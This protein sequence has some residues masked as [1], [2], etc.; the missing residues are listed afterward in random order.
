MLTFNKGFFEKIIGALSSKCSDEWFFVG[1]K[2][3][4]V[5]PFLLSKSLLH[6]IKDF[7][8]AIK[9]LN[10]FTLRILSCIAEISEA[11][12]PELMKPPELDVFLERICATL[13]RV[14]TIRS[15][16]LAIEISQS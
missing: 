7:T 3:F 12:E 8:M 5:N 4:F 1:D 6:S 11:A 14:V 2:G 13:E 15:K 16:T 9:H 10:P